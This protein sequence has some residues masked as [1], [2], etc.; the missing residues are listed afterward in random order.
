MFL[1]NAGVQFLVPLFGL[2]GQS[3]GRLPC[4]VSFC[5]HSCKIYGGL[6]VLVAQQFSHSFS[7]VLVHRHGHL[8]LLVLQQL[9]HLGLTVHVFCGS[10]VLVQLVWR[11][12][13]GWRR[14]SVA[15]KSEK[16]NTWETKISL[17]NQHETSTTDTGTGTAPLKQSARGSTYA[18]KIYVLCGGVRSLRFLRPFRFLSAKQHS[19][20]PLSSPRP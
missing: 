7:V 20:Q 16:T 6:C 3:S 18:D 14:T 19:M 13:Q 8:F 2:S 17:D 10:W 1:V 9:L 11:R 12:R 15:G 4:L 5:C